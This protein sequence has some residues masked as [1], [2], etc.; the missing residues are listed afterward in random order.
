MTTLPPSVSWLSSKCGSL[1]VSQSY[2]SSCPVTRMA[3][4]PPTPPTKTLHAFLFFSMRS[5]CPAHFI[6]LW[7]D[8]Y[9]YICEEYSTSFEART[10]LNGT[11]NSTDRK[12]KTRPTIWCL[13][14]VEIMTK[15]L[16]VELA[17]IFHIRE[18]NK[19]PRTVGLPCKLT[20]WPTLVP[21]VNEQASRALKSEVGTWIHLYMNCTL[22]HVI[23]NSLG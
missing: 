13:V 3:L 14:F 17:C 9:N 5:A 18:C 11:L 15:G 2:G 1:D 10:E 19:A 22:T 6:L 21:A 20:F 4:L 23:I 16:T 12:W 7:L 8:H